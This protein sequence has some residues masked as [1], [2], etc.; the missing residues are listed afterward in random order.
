MTVAMRS[1]PKGNEPKPNEDVAPTTTAIAA[2]A[3]LPPRRPKTLAEVAALADIPLPPMRPTGLDAAERE[4]ALAAPATETTPAEP[5]DAGKLVALDHPLPP[6]RSQVMP[7]D[8]AQAATVA[9]ASTKTDAAAQDNTATAVNTTDPIKVE[10]PAQ[11]VRL[12]H[13]LPPPRPIEFASATA[14]ATAGSPN[15]IVR[16]AQAPNNAGAPVIDRDRESLKAL[17][18]AAALVPA[19][20]PA[21]APVKVANAV[22]HAA[23]PRATQE[24]IIQP[25]TAAGHFQTTPTATP[26]LNRFSGRAVEPLNSLGFTTT[27]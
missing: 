2:Y 23:L 12:D 7:P 16:I 3:P 24:I 18:D 17:F 6:L 25:T 11:I 14:P 10:L 22:V 19:R 4:L 9:V 20:R 8:T 26:V 21:A 5:N 1:D 15:Q 13:P 27:Q